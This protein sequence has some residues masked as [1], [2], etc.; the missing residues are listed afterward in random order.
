MYDVHDKGMLDENSNNFHGQNILAYEFSTL[1]K[2]ITEEEDVKSSLC[3]LKLRKVSRLM[4][5]Q[6][7]I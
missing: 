3:S 5:G 1:D 6:I 4:F 2:V 7:N